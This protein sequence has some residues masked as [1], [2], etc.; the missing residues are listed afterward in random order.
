ML[1]IFAVTA[2]VLLISQNYSAAQD[3]VFSITQADNE[4][5]RY[6]QYQNAFD[7][8]GVE[9]QIGNFCL[10]G[11]AQKQRINFTPWPGEDVVI[12][13][14]N[15]QGIDHSLLSAGTT[16][17]FD[18]PE[19]GGVDLQFYRQLSTWA[20]S[21]AF[22]DLPPG[23]EDPDYE[24]TPWDILDN[25]EWVVRVLRASDGEHLF[26]VDSCG[27]V[28]H[29]DPSIDARYGVNSNVINHA[30]SLPAALNGETVYL[31]IVPKR[32]GP[33]SFGM[34]VYVWHNWVN[35]SALYSNHG[36]RLPVDE[37]MKQIYY[38]EVVEHFDAVKLATGWTPTK[39]Y[40]RF[41]QEQLDDL[42]ERYMIPEVAGGVTTWYEYDTSQNN[43]ISSA[44]GG[45]E[46]GSG[47]S[48]VLISRVN[49]QPLDREEFSIEFTVFKELAFT[50]TLTALS[51][52]SLQELWAGELP[53]GSHTIRLRMDNSN[54]ADGAY[55]L[56]AKSADGTHVTGRAIQIRR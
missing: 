43:I 21:N 41:T 19:E 4:F 22:P 16:E 35:L 27:V 42:Q 46:R 2:C 8:S 23:N 13:G 5:L 39:R 45:D 38:D 48:A 17:S 6:N 28:A 12:Y 50:V 1:K 25:S 53:V 30:V 36:S 14:Q 56:I 20:P 18:I 31:Q 49:P 52:R 37:E 3:T 32:T 47:G 33:T 54:L 15:A 11:P 7:Y 51:G 55:V 9:Y 44:S 40:L 29:S 34:R 10:I 26:T 24:P